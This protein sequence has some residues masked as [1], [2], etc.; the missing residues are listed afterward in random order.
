MMMGNRRG[1]AAKRAGVL[2][3]SFRRQTASVAGMK[4]IMTG[5][6]LTV[7]QARKRAL[8]GDGC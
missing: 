1:R 4:T 7:G 5:A 3:L 2:S 8:C 6:E